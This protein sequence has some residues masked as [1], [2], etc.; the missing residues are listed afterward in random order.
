MYCKRIVSD[1]SFTG[2]PFARLQRELQEEAGITAAELVQHGLII[3]DFVDSPTP[4]EVHI[5]KATEF[6]GEVTESEEMRPQWFPL[7]ALPYESMWKDDAVWFPMINADHYFKG[8]A[9][10]RY[11]HYSLDVCELTL[12][13]VAPVVVA[14]SLLLAACSGTSP[15]ALVAHASESLCASALRKLPV[16]YALC[17]LVCCRGTEELLSHDIHTVP[18]DE[19]LL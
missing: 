2:D 13:A 1:K 18:Q 4:L 10:F 5:F 16:V 11:T 17:A 7:A 6:S 15:L 14:S 9:L 19:L 12:Q 3:F 8:R